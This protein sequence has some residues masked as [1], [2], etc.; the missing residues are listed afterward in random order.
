MLQKLTLKGFKSIKDCDL[1]LRPLKHSAGFELGHK[2][3][4][5][6]HYLLV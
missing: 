1:K 4:R 5:K 3:K 2:P 6:T